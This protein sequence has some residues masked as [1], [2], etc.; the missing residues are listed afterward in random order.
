MYA[1]QYKI[2]LW[3]GLLAQAVFV[4]HHASPRLGIYS[5]SAN[6]ISHAGWICSDIM[7]HI[8][9]DTLLH[10]FIL[11]DIASL[12]WQVYCQLFTRHRAGSEWSA[13]PGMRS[14][15]WPKVWRPQIIGGTVVQLIH[16]QLKFTDGVSFFWKFVVSCLLWWQHSLI[17]QSGHTTGQL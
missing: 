3:L 5:S 4:L 10:S 17:P 16:D 2:P 1:V 8:W 7:L 15:D 11:S 9:L 12:D 13:E 14:C 6:P